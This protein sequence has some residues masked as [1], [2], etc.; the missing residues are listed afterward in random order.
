[1]H[2]PLQRD[3]GVPM[4]GFAVPAPPSWLCPADMKGKHGRKPG[5][6]LASPVNTL[7]CASP[8]AETASEHFKDGSAKVMAEEEKREEGAILESPHHPSL[9]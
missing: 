8:S 7:I 9:E 6:P 5:L 4:A 2:L 1:M 3:N